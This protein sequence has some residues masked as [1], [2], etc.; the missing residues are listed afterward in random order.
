[1][2]WELDVLMAVGDHTHSGFMIG[3]RDHVSSLLITGVEEIR[4]GSLHVMSV[5]KHVLYKVGI[6]HQRVRMEIVST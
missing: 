4:T 1:M 5:L 6:K 2:T 3:G